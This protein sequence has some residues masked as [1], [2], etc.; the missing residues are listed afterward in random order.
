MVLGK[1][2]K[3]NLNNETFSSSSTLGYFHPTRAY[4]PL[5]SFFDPCRIVSS[6]TS[7]PTLCLLAAGLWVQYRPRELVAYDTPSF[8]PVSIYHH[9]PSIAGPSNPSSSISASFFSPKKEI[10]VSQRVRMYCVSL[11]VCQ[12]IT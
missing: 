2:L 10:T 8:V 3:L 6:F 5:S 12:L 4:I 9:P 7:T 11:I 1:L